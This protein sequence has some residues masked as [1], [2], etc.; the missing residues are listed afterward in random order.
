VY[1]W[2]LLPDGTAMGLGDT[3]DDDVR[4]GL[5]EDPL[6][7]VH[8]RA[9]SADVWVTRDLPGQPDIYVGNSRA[10][11]ILSPT[12]GPDNWTVRAAP[13]ALVV[14]DDPEGRWVLS[15][16]AL[17]GT[18]TGSIRITVPRRA[19]TDELADSARAWLLD[20]GAAGLPPG[21][22]RDFETAVAQIPIPDST[23]ATSAVL[24]DSRNR[25]WVQRWRGRWWETTGV[26]IYDVIDR[27]GR[28][29]GWV[30]VNR[31]FG[32]ILFIGDHDILFEWK[33]PLDVPRVR[34]HRWRRVASQ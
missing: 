24:V 34:R 7:L 15:V 1:I 3:G 5:V 33:G 28:W 32:R 2:E 16:Y 11:A 21:Q 8:V 29:L 25:L 4:K 17:D 10:P 30:K 6:R 19:V 26:D 9:G 31:S 18:V 12:I 27:S 20:V 22:R 14:A 23:P 13:R